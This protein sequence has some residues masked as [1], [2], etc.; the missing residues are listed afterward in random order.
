MLV[1]II[2]VLQAV[3]G[4]VLTTPPALHAVPE[5]TGN[6]E[7]LVVCGRRES[8]YRLKPVPLRYAEPTIPKAE[9][10]V[11]GGK[12][13]AETEAGSVGGVVSNRAMLRLKLPF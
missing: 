1:A 8:P 3:A 10:G 7:E 11:L 12:L 6:G 5:C 13:A 4:P 9:I 2:F